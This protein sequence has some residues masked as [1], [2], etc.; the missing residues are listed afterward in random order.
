MYVT[1]SV[2]QESFDVT[3]LLVKASYTT[4]ITGQA[5]QLSFTLKRD[6][7]N[8]LKVSLG[9]LVCFWSNDTKV[10]KGY[11]FKIETSEKEEYDI[12]AYD[13]MRY[14]QNHD[15]YFI[16][17]GKKTFM[18]FFSDICG[19]INVPWT[20]GMGVAPPM[21]MLTQQFFADKSYFDMIEHYIDEMNTKNT[22]TRYFL[23]D[24]FGKLELNEI[25]AAFNFGLDGI[26][27][28]SPLVIG[29]KSLLTGYHY[30]MDIDTNTYN[31]VFL[32]AESDEQGSDGSKGKHIAY[33]ENE[34]RSIDRYGL[35]RKI[36]TV[37]KGMTEAQ[38]QNYAKLLLDV[39]KQPT[40]SMNLK[41]IGF[42]GI[43]AGAGF[44]MWLEKLHIASNMY[45]IT[46]T[47]DY[48]GGNHTMSLDVE[49]TEVTEI[50]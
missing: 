4:T 18:Q 40:K 14:L 36:E 16:E 19:A 15:Y 42:D 39:G 34:Q 17:G 41:A 38:I 21:D 31:E 10:F 29:D 27:G 11:M 30:G 8:V 45:V 33:A 37:Q 35:L 24:N 23:R 2:S 9:S 26:L 3:E 25:T 7:N 28:G 20:L 50:L 44:V 12:L 43:Y 48:E 22:R 32:M 1:E 49:A 6:P 46:A 47:H 5:G 13:T